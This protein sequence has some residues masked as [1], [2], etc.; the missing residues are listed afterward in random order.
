M[1][2]HLHAAL[3]LN[4]SFSLGDSVATGSLGANLA[5]VVGGE[6]AIEG[7]LSVGVGAQCSAIGTFDSSLHQREI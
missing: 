7:L 5:S 4:Q 6:A 2:V 3:K 1:L